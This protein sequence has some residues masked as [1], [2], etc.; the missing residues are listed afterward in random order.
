MAK[1]VTRIM[2]GIGNQLFCYAAARRLALVNHAELVIDDVTG[3]SRDRVYRR[4][5]MLDHF[6]IS[7]RKATNYERMEP[8]ERYRRGL[9]KYIS[10]KLPFFEREYIEQERIEFDPRFLEYRT[11]NNIYIDGL[12]QSENYFKD[13]EDI[14]RDDLKIIPPTDLETLI[15]QKNK[16]Y[17]KHHCDARSMVRFAWNKFRQ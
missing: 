17:T 2:G 11:Y 8:F 7:A 4:R 10:K 12:W 1:I 3:F 16:K 6:N 15:S 14:I 9:A 5:Y 13:V